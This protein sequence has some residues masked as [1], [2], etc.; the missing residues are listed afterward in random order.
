[1]LAKE[2]ADERSSLEEE[3]RVPHRGPV[4]LAAR[5]G[6]VHQL[7]RLDGARQA[8]LAGRRS[9]E[10]ELVELAQVGELDERRDRGKRVVGRRRARS[11]CVDGSAVEGRLG[12]KLRRRRASRAGR[13]R[14]WPRGLRASRPRRS[15]RRSSIE[16]NGVELG[17]G[18][19][20][21]DDRLLL[22]QRAL[23]AREI[24]AGERRRRR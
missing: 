24:E 6:A 1:M 12:Q 13:R 7:G 22:V 20:E 10:V 8:G 15:G 5:D 23:L 9:V 3:G 17:A 19:G 18:P 2:R 11:V 14:R 4:V 21:V 16:P